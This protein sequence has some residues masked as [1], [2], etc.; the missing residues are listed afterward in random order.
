MFD[1]TFCFNNLLICFKES[2]FYD[3][4]QSINQKITLQTVRRTIKNL[5][6]IKIP[7]IISLMNRKSRETVK[8][9]IGKCLAIN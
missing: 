3:E 6:Y 2:S 5:I 7:K 9:H 4:L 1:F 8:I